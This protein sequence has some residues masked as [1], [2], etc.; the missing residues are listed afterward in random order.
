MFQFLVCST[1]QIV[2]NEQFKW[3][4]V[5]E[6]MM[7]SNE[8]NFI[9]IGKQ[10]AR[11]KCIRLIERNIE[12]NAEK[13]PY[14]AQVTKTRGLQPKACKRKKNRRCNW[15]CLGFKNIGNWRS[16][17]K[18]R[19]TRCQLSDSIIKLLCGNCIRI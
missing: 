16:K 2:K 8:E 6:Q 13:A 5:K 18:H 7:V 14:F 1:K 11:R 4:K 17:F 9:R 19:C 3:E 10:D 12:S 15:T